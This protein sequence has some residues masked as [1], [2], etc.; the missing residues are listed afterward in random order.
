MRQLLPKTSNIQE[1][2]KPVAL[3]SAWSAW[4]ADRLPR[5]EAAIIAAL[6]Q[7]KKAPLSE[8]LLHFQAI[9]AGEPA[10]K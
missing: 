2:P 1:L 10:I 4:S 9:S 8:R 7:N 3:R 6:P 5:P